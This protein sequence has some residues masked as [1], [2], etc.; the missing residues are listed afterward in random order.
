MSTQ[1]TRKLLEASVDLR[2]YEC[3]EALGITVAEFSRA[4][5]E[6]KTDEQRWALLHPV[7]AFPTAV[8]KEES[9]GEYESTR[10]ATNR[11]DRQ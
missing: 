9:L 10:L 8:T 11:G 1:L 2:N 7:P 5:S 3:A 4:L 6:A